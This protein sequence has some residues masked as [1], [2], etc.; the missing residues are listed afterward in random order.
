[1]GRLF[2]RSSG[3]SRLVLGFDAGCMSCNELAKNI[4]DAVGE[5]LEVRSLR[6]P[7]V[8][9]WREEALG[10]DALWAPT[11]IEVR[12]EEVRAWTGVR[13]GMRLSRTLGPKD[14]WRVMQVLGEVRNESSIVGAN[15]NTGVGTG[16]TRAQFLKGVG[17][18]ALA[19]SVL[20]GVST[21][22]ASATTGNEIESEGRSC[23]H[24][25]TENWS[26]S[27]RG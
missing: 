10:E 21:T 24:L 1:M 4:E 12:G 11:L 2:G 8:Y 23:V 25:N 20:S 14:T 16:L 18:A 9:R 27:T 15:S 26:G 19:M 13:M 7:Q 6:D 22:P 17:G 3:D 5:R